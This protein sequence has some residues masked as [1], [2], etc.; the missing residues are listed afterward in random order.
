MCQLP[1]SVKN[2]NPT[3]MTENTITRG[4]SC[5]FHPLLM[6]VYVLLVLLNTGSLYN[7]EIPLHLKLILTGITVLTTILFPLA[8]TFILLRVK[9]ISSLFMEKREERVYPILAAAVFYYVTYYLLKGMQVSMIFSFYMLG[10][11]FL[12]ICS[13]VINF[14]NKISL[15]MIAMGSFVGL[16]VGLTLNFGLNFNIQVVAGILVSGLAGYA[17]LKANAHQPAEIYSG[18]L[19]GAVVISLLV[20]LL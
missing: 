9:V 16:F 14:Y 11:T 8:I 2:S 3:F 20:F 5:I 19:M 18:F 17:R 15:H 7:F 10:A 12:S 13:L 4:L 6:P 1:A